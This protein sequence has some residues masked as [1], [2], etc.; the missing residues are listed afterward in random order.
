MTPFCRAIS[1]TARAS[2]ARIIFSPKV[3]GHHGTASKGR[4]PSEPP[5]C[6]ARSMASSASRAASAKLPRQISINAAQ[7]ATAVKSFSAPR[8]VHRRCSA[9]ILARA[10]SSCPVQASTKP[11]TMLALNGVSTSMS[12]SSNSTARRR[13]TSSTP[14]PY[15]KFSW[16]DIASALLMSAGSPS[17]SAYGH[18]L[19]A[20]TNDSSNFEIMR[21]PNASTIRV[22]TSKAGLSFGVVE[23]A[24]ENSDGFSPVVVVEVYSGQQVERASSQR[25]G[26]QPVHCLFEQRAGSLRVAG[27]EMV[28]AP[29][30]LGVRAG[31]RRGR[32]RVRPTPPQRRVRPWPPRLRP[33][34]QE[35]AAFPG[36]RWR[37][38]A[39]YA[40]PS[41]RARLRSA[42]TTDAWHGARPRL[43]SV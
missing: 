40:W 32:S 35:R 28:F 8:S 39:P 2:D 43:A 25:P 16:T 27:V 11:S 4:S 14:C 26:W 7:L 21:W 42:P 41:V 37:P 18:R 34:C 10:S 6:S 5:P 36:P 12:G 9:C 38:R 17:C 30:G 1:R 24:F 20:L 19:R 29:H 23:R 31:R 3:S 22:C 13:L 33:R 15:M